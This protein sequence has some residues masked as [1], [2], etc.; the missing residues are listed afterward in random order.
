LKQTSPNWKCISV[1]VKLAELPALVVPTCR[2]RAAREVRSHWRSCVWGRGA[3]AWGA[4]QAA[5]R[6]RPQAAEQL[7]L[8]DS[9]RRETCAGPL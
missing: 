2:R 4:A 5:E 3:P 6:V 7:R 1:A 9:R 8:L